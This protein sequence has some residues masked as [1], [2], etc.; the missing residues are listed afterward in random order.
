VPFYIGVHYL[1]DYLQL[2]PL[3]EHDLHDGDPPEI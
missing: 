2:D 3:R 1:K